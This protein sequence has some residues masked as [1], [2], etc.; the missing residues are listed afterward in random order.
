M[1]DVR[2]KIDY[3]GIAVKRRNYCNFVKEVYWGVIYPALGLEK[4]YNPK[5]GKKDLCK[6]NWNA[7]E[8]VHKALDSLESSLMKL[9][10]NEVD[11]DDF[12]ISASIKSN[13]KGPPCSQCKA[14]GKMKTCATHSKDK[15]CKVCRCTLCGGRGV[16]VN[17][18]H[19]QLAKRMKERDE[20][21]API[22][23]Q[24]FGFIIVN[25]STR[26]SELSARSED[27]KYAKQNG[28]LPDYLFYL[29]QQIRKPLTKFLALLDRSEETEAIFG[30]VQ[31]LLFEQLRKQRRKMELEAMKEF[32]NENGKRP[33]AVEP[34]KKPKKSTVSAQEKKMKKVA[35]IPKI[36]DFFKGT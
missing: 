17:L 4:R 28:L 24:R 35:G 27:P 32:F 10:K 8:R 22:S 31:D 2:W 14:K 18:P 30:K 29:D 12:V 6:A 9:V 16:I 13:Y 33:A 5:T 7:A 34:L 19:I 15:D 25:D 1:D 26:S 3:K 21:S 36:S 20:G 23:G 11:M